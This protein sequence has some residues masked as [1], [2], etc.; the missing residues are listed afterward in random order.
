MTTAHRQKLSKRL[1]DLLEGRCE[2][3][4]TFLSGGLLLSYTPPDTTEPKTGAMH[5]LRLGRYVVKRTG[6]LKPEAKFPSKTE[7]R[8]ITEILE[9]VNGFSFTNVEAGR[10][11]T[12]RP[13]KREVYGIVK[14]RWPLAQPERML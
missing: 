4:F 14:I 13:S 8:V 6:Y 1:E 12:K 3:N 7:V 5:E 10:S 11:Y 2:N 9:D